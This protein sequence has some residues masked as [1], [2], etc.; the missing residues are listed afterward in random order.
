MSP[1]LFSPKV[2]NSF[3]RIIMPNSLTLFPLTC[4]ACLGVGIFLILTANLLNRCN[5]LFCPHSV[6]ADFLVSRKLFKKCSIH[7]IF[8]TIFTVTFK[9]L[10]FCLLLWIGPLF[11]FIFFYNGF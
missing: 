10:F 4:F 9:L 1:G 11:F 8:I 6:N 5:V 3:V 2:F 7:L